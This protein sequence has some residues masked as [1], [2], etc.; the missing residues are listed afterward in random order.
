[1]VVDEL[2]DLG[3]HF[4]GYLNQG[5]IA[6]DLHVPISSNDFIEPL[7]GYPVDGCVPVPLG[8]IYNH[9]LID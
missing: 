7:G 3:E 2:V 5:L 4:L 6:N 8:I 1:M 9:R